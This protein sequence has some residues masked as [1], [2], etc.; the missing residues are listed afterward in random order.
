MKMGERAETMARFYNSALGAVADDDTL[1]ERLFAPA[2]PPEPGGTAPPAA[3]SREAL[4]A[5]KRLY[6]GLMGWDER[7]RPLAAK[8]HELDLGW[9]L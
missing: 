2:E 3:V 7:G 8:L 1:P 9:L 5:A 6:Y 4:E